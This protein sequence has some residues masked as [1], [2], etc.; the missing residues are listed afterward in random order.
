[1]SEKPVINKPKTREDK[2]EAIETSTGE[3]EKMEEA[4][5]LSINEDQGYD[6]S[7]IKV[8]EG[9]EA[10]R[11]RPDMYIGGTDGAG[12][13]HL[14]YEVLDNAIDEAWQ[15]ACE[16]IQVH[17]YLDGSGSVHDDGRGI[18]VGD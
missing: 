17:L 6:A 13:H 10:V 4:V 5:T 11:K 8:L 15:G 16:N 12:L 3:R 18:P 2:V 1:M 7:S 14:V 9:L